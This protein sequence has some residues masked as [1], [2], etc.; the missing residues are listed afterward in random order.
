M[1]PIVS[2]CWQK[3]R[4]RHCDHLLSLQYPLVE[5][6]TGA[7]FLG[8]PLYFSKLYNIPLLALNGADISFYYWK[9]IVWIFAFVIFL[10]IAAIDYRLKV[11]PNE[12]NVALILLGVAL[13]LLGQATTT[14]GSYALLFGVIKN[15]W[16][17]HLLAAIIGG[18]I[19]GLIILLTRGKAMGMGDLKL[20]FAGGWLLGWPDIAASLLLAFIVGGLWG[21]GLIA[22][23]KKKFKDKVPFGPFIIAGFVLIFFFGEFLLGSYLNLLTL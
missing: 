13:I 10:L 23:K 18:A 8:I 19:F 12:L 2:F 21:I 22:F 20:G 9:S 17:N 6:L 16:L 3:K 15:I 5:L 11:I 1:I 7:I 4:C 14:L